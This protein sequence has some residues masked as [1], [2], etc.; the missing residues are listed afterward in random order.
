MPFEKDGKSYI[1]SADLRWLLQKLLNLNPK[2]A[3]GIVG[4]KW[5]AIVSATD[6]NE[7]IEV[8]RVERK[9][10]GVRRDIIQHAVAVHAFVGSAAKAGINIRNFDLSIL[11]R[12]YPR[13]RTAKGIELDFSK[14]H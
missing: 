3:R 6:K 4:P 14:L 7:L 2:Q 11:P 8:S 5:K 13:T 10:G 1:I 12:T 9:I